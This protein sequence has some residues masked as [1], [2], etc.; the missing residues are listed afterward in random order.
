[1]TAMNEAVFLLDVDIIL[2]CACLSQMGRLC[3][4]CSYE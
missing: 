3:F 2:E 4:S 1:M